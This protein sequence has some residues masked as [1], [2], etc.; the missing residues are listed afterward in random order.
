[1]DVDQ[2]LS[3]LGTSFLGCPDYTLIT[4]S[5]G[6]SYTFTQMNLRSVRDG[7]STHAIHIGRAYRSLHYIA[8][9]P[10]TDDGLKQ[11]RWE[12]NFDEPELMNALEIIQ[13]RT[14]HLILDFNA[15]LATKWAL[16]VIPSVHRYRELSSLEAFLDQFKPKIPNLGLPGFAD[17]LFCVGCFF[18]SPETSKCDVVRMD[19]RYGSDQN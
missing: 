6:S 16:H 3:R 12:D 14:P 9:R 11:L 2:Q 19:K 17:Y 4:L 1:M 8:N 5:D 10:H 13:H 7:L 18:L 15:S